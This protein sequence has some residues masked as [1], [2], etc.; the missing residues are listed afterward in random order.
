[1]KTINRFVRSLFALPFFPPP[2]GFLV[3]QGR[4]SVGS[5]L[6]L[7]VY[8]L[9]VSVGLA[10]LAASLAELGRAVGALRQVAT[11]LE[12]PEAADFPKAPTVGGKGSKSIDETSHHSGVVS[13]DF[14][15]DDE[16]GPAT[17]ERGEVEFKDVWFKYRGRSDW[18]LR[19]FSL[20][21]PAGSLV[22][23]V[24][25]SGG[26]KSTAA[27]LLLGLYEPATGEVAVDGHMVRQ[28]DAPALRRSM[29]LVPQSPMLLSG[30]VAEQIRLGR[31]HASDQEVQAAA[32]AADAAGFIADLHDEYET[33][34]GQRGQSLSGGQRQRLAIAR[35]LVRRP[36]VLI[37]DEAT[38]ALD[39]RTERA[40]SEA[41]RGL[42]GATRLV[43]AHR[44]STVRQADLIA[45]VEG[46]KVV[47]QG[48]HDELMA[49][50]GGAYRKMVQA[51]A[52]DGPRRQGDGEGAAEAA[53]LVLQPFRG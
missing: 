18:A 16:A 8:N 12:E 53:A 37:L 51:A 15:E 36:R 45:V 19:G 41:L 9:F 4:I 24:G 30:T 7:N 20:M 43:I 39:A 10:S 38:S 40:V 49:K 47:E 46:G 28:V 13:L 35:A 32:V 34:V 17:I 23:L 3:L 1:M 25:A 5:V 11:L 31:P 48:T 42:K 6:S 26:G 33:Q 50:T 29:A 21:V 2:K 52:A 44:L 27:A 22:A 14:E